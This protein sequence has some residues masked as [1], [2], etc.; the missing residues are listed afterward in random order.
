MNSKFKNSDNFFS[1]AKKLFHNIKT[2][3]LG[4]V[5]VFDKSLLFFILVL[6]LLLYL[7]EIKIPNLFNI[8]YQAAFNILW[9]IIGALSSIMGIVIAIMLLAFEITQK[10]YNFYAFKTFLGDE[11][12][13]ILTSLFLAAI[14]ISMITSLTLSDPLIP[15]NINLTYFSMCLFLVSL[16][17]LL[18]YSRDI[19][20]QTQSKEKI[21]KIV[22]D[23]DPAV[24]NSTDYFKIPMEQ[25]EDNPLFILSDIGAMSLENSDQLTANVILFECNEKLLWM[26]SNLPDKRKSINAFLMIIKIISDR[27][28]KLQ[29]KSTLI[30]ILEI[31]Y[32]IHIF[33]ANNKLLW[34]E[35]IEL[36]EFIE[37]FLQET[38]K[39]DL[40]VITRRGLYMI[41][42]IMI[43]HL[44]K[45]IPNENEISRLHINDPA[46]TPIDSDKNLQWDHVSNDYI[47]IISNIIEESIEFKNAHISS[48]GLASL[49]NISSRIAESTLGD[50]QKADILWKTYYY[51][52]ILSIKS[53]DNNLH[54]KTV[55]LFPFEPLSI[56]RA[57]EKHAE[58]SKIPL[59]AFSEFL[60]KSAQKDSLDI[61]TLNCLGTIGRGA[62]DK[63]NTNK[64]YKEALILIIDVVN[65]LKK[66]IEI[67]LSE[68]KKDI[69][70]ELY[71]QTESLKKWTEKITK[72]DIRLEKILNTTL[73]KF[74][75]FKMVKKE[76]AKNI[77]T[78]PE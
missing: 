14:T 16:F 9:G 30:A 24:I 1:E 4:H 69:Y 29:S 58:F 44:Y 60:L 63:L 19:I 13:K 50:L 33:C 38:A 21:K 5:Y 51:A 65:K 10:K 66:I 55:F 12:L 15:K 42:D 70:L 43:E 45:N 74:D 68:E 67:N 71:R 6:S 3:L 27:A 61:F 62:A 7:T 20:F 53:I 77:I 37:N 25:I 32:E 17:C 11:K 72:K 41:E 78:W 73:L 31:I 52:K 56:L 39:F 8:S 22:S 26:L 76:Q 47:K 57:L 34:D 18:P 40:D 35:T 49:I 28:I 64:I 48:I 23:I 75:K 2:Q 54:K 36:N 59:V 46:S